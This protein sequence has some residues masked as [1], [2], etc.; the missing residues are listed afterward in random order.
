MANLAPCI[1]SAEYLRKG[2]FQPIETWVAYPKLIYGPILAVVL[3]LALING[4]FTVENYKLRV[5]TLPLVG[6]IF[7]YAARRTARLVEKVI[8][9]FLGKAEQGIA[10]GPEAASAKQTALVND[11]KNALKPRN[12]E[13]LRSQAKKLAKEI[14]ENEVKK[15]EGK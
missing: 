6:F 8:E 12:M 14:T 15:G 5:W 4:F 7:G 10:K 9:R 11:L 13:D 2:D 3:V 1:S